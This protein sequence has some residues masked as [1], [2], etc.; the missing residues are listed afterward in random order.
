MEE[1]KLRQRERQAAAAKRYREKKK[2]GHVTRHHRT[3]EE[4]QALLAKPDAELSHNEKELVR[5]YRRQAQRRDRSLSVN[6][7]HSPS[8]VNPSPKRQRVIEILSSLSQPQQQLSSIPISLHATDRRTTTSTSSLQDGNTSA[9]QPQSISSLIP[10]S[11]QMTSPLQ[12]PTSPLHETVAT[13]PSAPSVQSMATTATSLSVSHPDDTSATSGIS[14]SSLTSPLVH[15]F[16]QAIERTAQSWPTLTQLPSIDFKSSIPESRSKPYQDALYEAVLTPSKRYS[17]MHYTVTTS[18]HKSAPEA[19]VAGRYIRVFD[20]SIKEDTLPEG[21]SNLIQELAASSPVTS[22][23]S[24][25]ASEVAVQQL[26]H[27]MPL[28]STSHT[29][30]SFCQTLKT[31]A[32]ESPPVFR[33]T[34]IRGQANVYQRL[35]QAAFSSTTSTNPSTCF[36]SINNIATPFIGI[37]DIHDETI[38]QR[39]KAIATM[40]NEHYKHHTPR[41]HHELDCDHV[42]TPPL[43]GFG[44][45][46]LQLYIKHGASITWLHDE[47][48]WCAALNYMLKHS[49]GCTL[50][51][52]VGL[53]DLKQTLSMMQIDDLLRIPANNVKVGKLLDTLIES[54]A[55]IEY[56]FQKP[57]Q[58]IS[59]PPG[60]GAAHLVISNGPLLSQLAWNISFTIPGALGCLSFWGDRHSIFGHV[61]PDNG[62]M[63]TPTVVPLYT[64]QQNGYD[65]NLKDKIQFY[66]DSIKQLQRSNPNQ[67]HLIESPPKI[68]S[69]HCAKCLWRQ[70]WLRIDRKCV[71]CYFNKRHLSTSASS[72]QI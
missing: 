40:I 28:T 43:D 48:L 57:G 38:Q 20:V 27:A 30:L 33:S 7:S 70:D 4:Q 68:S 58:Y 13:T 72:F 12:Q 5:F 41:Q 42:F 61:S 23:S 29:L 22:S 63:A 34:R 24:A 69:P 19:T 66:L 51:I 17:H 37:N 3:S 8:D 2:Q 56:V 45:Q 26:K 11:S 31:P 44:I 54:N 35:T 47:I 14:A 1:L 67:Q 53:N 21:F 15:P 64:M 6:S 71:H 60:V 25:P 50:W 49:I 62:S 55:H 59:T 18:E 36:H 46:G 10:T 52:A 32:T 16:V 65:F 39:L 9:F